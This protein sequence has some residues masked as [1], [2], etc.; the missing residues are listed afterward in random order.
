MAKRVIQVERYSKQS[1]SGLI[2]LVVCALSIAIVGCSNQPAYTLYRDSVLSPAM[3]IHVATFD[4]SDGEGYNKENCQLAAQLFQNQ[5]G[6]STK[7]WCEKG[8]FRK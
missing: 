2:G 5:P 3:R 8:D 1:T 4:A 6:I 7:F